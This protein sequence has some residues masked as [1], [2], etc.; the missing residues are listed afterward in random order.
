M[1]LVD[2]FTADHRRCDALW[3]VLETALDDEDPDAIGAAWS[4]FSRATRGH[5]DAEEQVLFPAFEAATGM[6]HGPTSVM[7]EE[8]AQ[9]RALLDRLDTALAR[10]DWSGALDQGDTLLML[11][12][13]HNTKEE[14]VLYP[15]A[16]QRLGDAWEELRAA[17]MRHTR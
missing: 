10:R 1:T 8:H 14:G 15:M 4:A 9:M 16:E 5:L 2:W 17:A 11:L 13:Q 6:F 12:Q 3:I 7:R